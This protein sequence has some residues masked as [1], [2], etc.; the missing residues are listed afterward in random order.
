MIRERFES[1]GLV[2][3]AGRKLRTSNGSLDANWLTKN[4]VPT[5][6]FGAGQNAIHTVEEW[7]NLDD[8][9]D[10]WGFALALAHQP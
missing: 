7:V 3:R 2:F 1:R 8:Y 6:T 5:I 9:V 4:G 10:G